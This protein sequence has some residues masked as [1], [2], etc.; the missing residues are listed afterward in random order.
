MVISNITR[1][2]GATAVLLYLHDYSNCSITFTMEVVGM[3]QGV[4]DIFIYKDVDT[5]IGILGYNL[6]P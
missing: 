4:T 6:D 5:M 1:K 2:S 3:N